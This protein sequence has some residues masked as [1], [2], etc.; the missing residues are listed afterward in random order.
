MENILE[1]LTGKKIRVITKKKKYRNERYFYEPDIVPLMEQYTNERISEIEICCNCGQTS[2]IPFKWPTNSCCRFM[3][4]VSLKDYA[5][6][7]IYRPYD[8]WIE[9]IKLYDRS[10]KWSKFQRFLIKTFKI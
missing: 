2:N 5:K 3:N 9:I 4:R 8:E 7:S 1:F 10:L 6:L